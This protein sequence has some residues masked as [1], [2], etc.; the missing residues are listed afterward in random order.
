MGT[1]ITR[2]QYKINS[3]HHYYYQVMRKTIVQFLDLFNDLKIARYDTQTGQ[4]LS[5]IKVPL[6]FAPKSKNW[7]WME[8]LDSNGK[9]IKDKIMPIMAVN[10][11]DIEIATDRKVNRYYSGR[12]E[13]QSPS[14]NR[15]LSVD[16]YLNPTPYNYTFQLQILA[17]Y[18]VDITQIM[19]QFL[20]YFNPEYFI[21]I[22]IPELDINGDTTEELNLKVLYNGSN[23]EETLTM[24][25]DEY[26]HIQWNVDFTVEGYLFQP[27]YAYPVIKTIYENIV[28]GLPEAPESLCDAQ[29]TPPSAGTLLV[30]E[31]LSAEQFPLD[32]STEE[33]SGSIYDETI[34]TIYKYE[35]N[36]VY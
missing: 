13:S 27:K 22:S 34:K 24:G 21:N 20:P 18:M 6:K 35:I 1:D 10:L 12:N 7:Y 2:H 25:P 11:V 33:L 14:A 29:P 9:R 17:E 19:E 15:L 31:G 28:I 8:K 16:R 30:T 26:R 4:L 32:V 3:G 5:F 23:K 36:E